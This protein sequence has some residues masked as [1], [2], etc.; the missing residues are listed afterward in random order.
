MM[1][2]P[3]PLLFRGMV[4]VLLVYLIKPQCRKPAGW[5]GRLAVSDMNR[6]HSKLISWGLEHVD[7]RRT[8]SALDVGC[9]GG[10]TIQRLANLADQGRIY[11]V[12]YSKA[13]VAVSHALNRAGIEAGRVDI[14]LATVS[15]LPFEDCVFDLVTAV[16]THYY[17][18]HRTED[19]LEIRR[20]LKPGGRVVIIAEAYSGR[21]FDW[22]YR[23]SMK[24]LG[25]AYLSPYEHRSLLE[26]AGYVESQVFLEKSKGWICAVGSK[27]W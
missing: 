21:T 16:E 15:S 17:W 11:G 4:L 19:L 25:G 27:P 10:R 2:H 9:G 13:A 18:P 23:T 26:E 8:Y 20:V 1:A 12:D 7:I 3:L 5:L 22:A 14:R 6:R 24:L